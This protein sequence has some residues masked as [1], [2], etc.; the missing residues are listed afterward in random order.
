MPE[1]TARHRPVSVTENPPRRISA[2][3]S[4]KQLVYPRS[5][6]PCH[7]L[8]DELNIGATA[9]LDEAR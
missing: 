8:A 5:N 1:I 4:G 3:S 6:D 9:V 2:F 7:W